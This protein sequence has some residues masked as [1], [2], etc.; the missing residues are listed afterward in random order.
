MWNEL[1]DT[2]YNLPNDTDDSLSTHTSRQQLLVSSKCTELIDTFTQQLQSN[3]I[4]LNDSLLHTHQHINYLKQ[5]LIQ[6]LSSGYVSL[7]SSRVWILYWIL[8]SMTLLNHTLSESDI[9]ECTQW[10]SLCQNTNGGY[11]GG[12]QQ[13][14]HAAPTF[15]AICC[16]Y[17][18]AHMTLLND[19]SNISTAHTI[20]NTVNRKQLYQWL[21]SI[22]QGNGGFA[23]HV[24]GGEVDTRGTYC[25]VAT[26]S[27]LNILDEKLSNGT[28]EFISKS[29]TYEGMK[30]NNQINICSLRCFACANSSYI[31]CFTC[32]C[33][34]W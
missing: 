17:I 6:S 18:L 26:A 4:E 21:S 15:A 34:W 20:Y 30:Q 24:N 5:G 2:L 7:D 22:K 13:I 11:G 29:I 32:R 25:C 14:S 12:P 33:Y 23:V 8:H 10:L 31:C 27:M 9:N 19:S 28:A 1:F 16:I 3:S